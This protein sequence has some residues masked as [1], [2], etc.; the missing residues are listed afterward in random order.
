MRYHGPLWSRHAAGT[1]RNNKTRGKTFIQT[2]T[3]AEI[4]DLQLCFLHHYLHRISGF[5]RREHTSVR[6]A[7]LE[8][9]NHTECYHYNGNGACLWNN[10]TQ[11]GLQNGSGSGKRK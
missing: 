4:G 5:N 6:K 7:G 11:T 1:S 8:Q 3:R 2:D 9:A 10:I